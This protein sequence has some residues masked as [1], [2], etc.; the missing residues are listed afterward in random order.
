MPSTILRETKTIEERETQENTLFFFSLKY[1]TG[2][3]Q[4]LLFSTYTLFIFDCYLSSMNHKRF[5]PVDLQINGLIETYARL[6]IDIN[7]YFEN[8]QVFHLSKIQICFGGS[9]AHHLTET[10]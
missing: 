9:Y 4:S 6:M 5:I 3:T 8:Y 1:F 2:R 7:I 10:N